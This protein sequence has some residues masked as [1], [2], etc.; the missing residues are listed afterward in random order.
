MDARGDSE[1]TGSREGP[2]PAYPEDV[3]RVLSHLAHLIDRSIELR[4]TGSGTRS[5]AARHLGLPSHRVV[6]TTRTLGPLR[7]QLTAL[8]LGRAMKEHPPVAVVGE[9]ADEPPRYEQ[10]DLGDERVSV[11]HT[12]AAAFDAGTVAPCALVV[13]LGPTFDDERL[14]CC[15]WSGADDAA[16]A[17][18][19]LGVL[20][21]SA[22]DSNPFRRRTLL[23]GVPAHFGL[24]F[25][26]ADV[27]GTTRDDLVLPPRVWEEVDASVHGLFASVDR[28]RAAGLACNR[29][30]LL[31]GPPGTG[32]TG[33]CRVLATELRGEV[34]IVFCDA[35]AV[36]HTV[37]SLYREL[38]HLAPALVVMEDLDLVVGHRHG[39]SDSLVG[40]LLALDGAM[41][42]HAGVVTV[43]TT[44]DP[45]AIDAA[46][47][48]AGRF[49][50]VV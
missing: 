40:F 24:R 48:R 7:F 42:A 34:T 23:A 14:V 29:G 28:L 3:A 10:L 45:D 21:E 50:R 1:L 12:L 31:A 36:V 20:I 4:G 16:V 46:A 19:W 11:P 9:D 33:I 38:E 13:S 5:F 22:H 18:D 32:K 35:K 39:G 6:C 30:L 47:R 49:D 26:V 27:V 37:E 8:A 2:A 44:N 15:V 43:A 41:S 17:A 25:T